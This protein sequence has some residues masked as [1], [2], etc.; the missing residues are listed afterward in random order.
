MKIKCYVCGESVR[1]KKPNSKKVAGVWVHK[2]CPVEAA[3]RKA[4]KKGMVRWKKNSGKNSG[5]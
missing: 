4:R 2:L 1:P 3:R 5:K